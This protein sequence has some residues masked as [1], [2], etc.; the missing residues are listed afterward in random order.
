MELDPLNL[1]SNAL[2]G[3]F[4]LHA[5][6]ANEALVRLVETA[7]LEPHF[8]L[9]RLFT[10][11]AY[12]ERGDFAEAVAEAQKAIE[13]SSGSTHAM[14]F[15]ACALAKLGK[16]AEARSVLEDLLKLSTER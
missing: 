15:G 5:G 1:L 12:Y 11:S 3:Q 13:S 8:W 6:R 2:E 16:R 10:S 4:L 14:S 7:E 9:A